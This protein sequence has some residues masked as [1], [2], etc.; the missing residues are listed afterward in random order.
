M[1][2][3][4]ITPGLKSS[5]PK[6]ERAGLSGIRFECH[7]DFFFFFFLSNI[8]RT[9]IPCTRNVEKT[10]F[11]FFTLDRTLSSFL[12]GPTFFQ[13]IF[14]QYAYPTFVE[15]PRVQYFVYCVSSFVSIALP[16]QP[17]F[18][19]EN[20]PDRTSIDPNLNFLISSQYSTRNRYGVSKI[21]FVICNIKNA[22]ET[23]SNA[24]VISLLNVR[25]I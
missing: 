14:L 16:C 3:F 21:I 12:L 7:Y 13:S 9:V 5:G 18:R 22:S 8:T 24:K 25:L 15:I 2:R 20:Q 6:V 19:F 4:S 10:S 11:L 1:F 17:W 23:I